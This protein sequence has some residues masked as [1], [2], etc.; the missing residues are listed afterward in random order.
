MR[1][2]AAD[3]HD[4]VC[5]AGDP[6]VALRIDGGIHGDRGTV[7]TVLDAVE[8]VPSLAPGLRTVLDLPLI[9]YR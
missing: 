9:A 1:L 7:G 2:D 6:P 3:A 4:G 5:I 8:R